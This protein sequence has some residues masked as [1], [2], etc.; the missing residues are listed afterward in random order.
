MDGLL[1]G[2]FQKLLHTDA[3]RDLYNSVK[4]ATCF[5]QLSLELMGRRGEATSKLAESFCSLADAMTSMPEAPVA[6]LKSAEIL[7][8]AA[9]EISE[10]RMSPGTL[11]ARLAAAFKDLRDL[12]G[13]MNAQ[14]V[15]GRGEACVANG[16]N[17]ANGAGGVSDGLP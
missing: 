5:T 13:R 4:A 3:V 11:D 8:R 6:Q 14:E 10:L 1:Q 9:R 15:S 12:H 2:Q 17:G 16:A 7:E